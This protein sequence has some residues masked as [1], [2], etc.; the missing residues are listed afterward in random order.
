MKTTLS[1]VLWLVSIVAPVS[2]NA[3]TPVF[4]RDQI[5]SILEQTRT[6]CPL[7]WSTAHREGSPQRW[8]FIIAAVQRLDR[9]S[10]GSVG[11]NWR[12]GNVGDLSMDGVTFRGT[13]GRF[14]FADVIGGAG[15]SNPSVT[16]NVTGEAPAHGFVSAADLPAPQIEC[17]PGSDD[18]IDP[19]KDSDLTTTARTILEVVQGLR[20][21]MDVLQS[22]VASLEASLASIAADA[23]N[24]ADRSGETK[25]IVQNT[26]D[27]LEDVIASQ[28][29]VAD[30]LHNPPA[31]VGSTKAFGGSVRLT[32]EPR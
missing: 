19:P 5:V 7:Q 28:N 32:A 8:D 17:N 21:Q 20:A 25:A 27:R 12:R 30:M 3:Q 2:A 4:P 14:W 11:G 10:S 16:F 6:D 26:R 29:T 15:G 23:R 9:A 22:R 18:P 31:Y 1:T 13:D 24:A